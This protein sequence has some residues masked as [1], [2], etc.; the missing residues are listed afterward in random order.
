MACNP[1]MIHGESVVIRSEKAQDESAVRAVN[2]SAF[3][4]PDEASLVD[5]L[6]K[7]G[8]VI[9]SL[10]AEMKNQVIGHV[11]FSRMWIDKSDGSVAAVALAP[12][13][14]LPGYQGRGVA[15]MLICTGLNFLRDAGEGIVVVLGHPGY[16]SRF[17]FSVEQT[18]G[19]TSPFPPEAFMAVEL[20]TNAL[21]GLCGA[22]RYPVAFGV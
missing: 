22:V 17:G 1:P 4:R 9:L 18:R 15:G 8:A 21:R 7:E 2:K 6:R 3:G 20:T 5:D 14:V 10:V 16:Y 11:L 12:V 13:A 19:L